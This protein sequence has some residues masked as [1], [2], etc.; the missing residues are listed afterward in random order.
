MIDKWL[1]KTK[2][3]EGYEKFVK[4]IVSSRISANQLTI[5]GLVIGLIS[6]LFIYLSS[7]F[8]ELLIEFIVLSIIFTIVSFFIDTLDGSVA[9]FEGPTIFGGILDIF[10]DRLVEATIIIAIV[11]T[12]PSKLVWPGMFSL[13]AII[14]CISMFLIVGGIIK[15]DELDKDTKVIKY[16][17]GLMERSETFFCLLAII[18]LIPWRFVILW[19]FAI[20]VFLTALLRLRA[21]YKIFKLKDA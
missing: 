4:K 20:L 21:A 5:V 16:Q 15:R 19:I 1:S 6:A 11:A 14:L 2:F 17:G 9:R 13:A 18:L 3:K 7:V 8:E 10:C 12:D